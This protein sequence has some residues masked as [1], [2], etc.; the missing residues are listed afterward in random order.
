MTSF[1]AQSDKDEPRTETQNRDGSQSM[2]MAK[3]PEDCAVGRFRGGLGP[4]FLDSRPRTDWP[5]APAQAA[6]EGPLRAPWPESGNDSTRNARSQLTGRRRGRR[7]LGAGLAGSWVWLALC[8][9]Q[10]QLSGRACGIAGTWRCPRVRQFQALCGSRSDRWSNRT[11]V[12]LLPSGSQAG[13]VK[14]IARI[15]D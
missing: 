1:N 3:A 2:K 4:F 13:S 7:E 9:P 11:T 10:G 15:R 8:S 6:D 12:P 5:V 14:I